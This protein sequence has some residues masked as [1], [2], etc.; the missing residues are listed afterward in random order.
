MK[1]YL[2][3]SDEYPIFEVEI[4]K[5]DK[6]YCDFIIYKAVSWDYSFHNIYE[7]KFIAEVHWKWDFCTHWRFYGDGRKVFQNIQVESNYKVLSELRMS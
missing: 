4:E 1:Y 2:K 3:D 5:L 7:K 6:Y